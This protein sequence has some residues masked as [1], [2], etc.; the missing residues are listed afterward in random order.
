MGATPPAARRPGRRAL[1]VLGA[2]AIVLLALLVLGAYAPG[3]PGVGLV[4]SFLSGYAAWTAVGAAA[5]TALAGWAF[6]RRRARA[7][8]AFTAV[9]ALSTVGALV[10]VVR[11]LALGAEHD[12]A[13]NPFAA[14]APESGPDAVV[15]YA[16][17]EGQDLDVAI[18]VPSAAAADGTAPI[19]L[20]VHGGGWISGAATDNSD[21]KRWFA[22]R[23]WL[24]LSVD[25]T[26]SSASR[27]L[28]D[29]SVRQVGCAM[30]WAAEH[31]AEHGGDPSRLAVLG[32]SAGGNL[33]INAAYQASAGTL[34]PSCPGE[35]PAVDAVAVVY[36][37]VDPV[38]FHDNPDP[39]MGGTAREMTEHYTGGTP[40]E[41]PERYAAI[42]SASH[43]SSAAPTTLIVAPQHDH[44]VPPS[45]A[46][47]FAAQARESGVEVELVRVPFADHVFDAAPLGGAL[48]RGVTEHWLRDRG[49]AP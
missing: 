1:L 40:T 24:V 34:E 16:Q 46:E 29:T 27:H 19:A 38:G 5:A 13:L 9:A 4:G 8:A 39:I 12:V 47:A 37:A 7:R 32:D 23:G 28:W 2:A 6:A 10:I 3:I 25:Y 33:A 22:D 31:A 17:H 30:A 26:L 41:H 48:A 21:D 11:L 44:L 45:G 42:A 36:P 43:I 14:A 18:W 35:V 15:A 20:F 49:L